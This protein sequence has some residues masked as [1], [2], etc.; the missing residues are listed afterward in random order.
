MRLPLARQF[1]GLFQSCYEWIQGGTF[2]QGEIHQRSRIILF[3]IVSAIVSILGL[4]LAV[5]RSP[6][7]LLLSLGGALSFWFLPIMRLKR[8]RGGKIYPMLPQ[9]DMSGLGDKTHECTHR[10][11]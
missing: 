5:S 2:K 7:W 11:N 9:P 6:F 10:S 3:Q 4:Y 8:I 1:D